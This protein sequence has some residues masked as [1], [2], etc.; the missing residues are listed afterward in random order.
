M[1]LLTSEVAVYMHVCSDSSSN[2]FIHEY[3]WRFVFVPSD[4]SE[5]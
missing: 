3:K 2:K 4:A 1:L 5:I